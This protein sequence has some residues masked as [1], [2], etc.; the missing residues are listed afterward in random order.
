MVQI[1]VNL[2]ENSIK[3]GKD[4]DVKEIVIRQSEDGNPV[5]V[6]VADSGPGIPG[7]DPKKVFND[8]YR[9]EN[10]ATSAAGGTGIG[11][12]MVR[13]FVTLSGGRVTAANNSKADS[14]IR[15][16]LPRRKIFLD[17]WP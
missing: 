7:R 2:L 6:E 13:R 16:D 15:I 4:I 9:A 1:S 8:F 11:L 17:R 5:H 3:F 10:V 12:A 14:T